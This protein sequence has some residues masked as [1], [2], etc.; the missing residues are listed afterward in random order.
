M[1]EASLYTEKTSRRKCLFRWYR[2]KEDETVG[3]LDSCTNAK[4]EL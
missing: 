3:V 4:K 1:K 2:S